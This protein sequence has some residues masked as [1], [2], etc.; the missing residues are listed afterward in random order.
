MVAYKSPSWLYNPFVDPT[1]I[2]KKVEHVLFTLF[3]Y[4]VMQMR[5]YREW[6]LVVVVMAPALLGYFTP[7][8]CDGDKYIPA[9]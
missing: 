3:T 5:V 8:E 6:E 2:N 4:N 9:L 1:F 7:E